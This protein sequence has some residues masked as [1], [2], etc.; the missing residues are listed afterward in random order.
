MKK[1]GFTLIE[2]LVVIAIIAILA[3][4]LLPA[5]QTAKNLARQTLC[6]GNLK[7]IG[8][9]V[10]SY[11]TDQAQNRLP[12]GATSATYG[13]TS[14][15]SWDDLVSDYIG[16]SLTESM[17]AAMYAP[18]CSGDNIFLCPSDKKESWNPSAN[19]RTYAMVRGNNAGTGNAAPDSLT[20]IFGVAGYNPAWSASLSMIPDPSGTLLI[21]EQT[22]GGSLLGYG[23]CAT[24][25]NPEAHQK[26]GILHQSS[27]SY[28]YVDIHAAAK[29][30]VDTFGPGGSYAQPRGQWTR[31]KGD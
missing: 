5:L 13:D 9:A 27:F 3:S 22:N 2:L 20:N 30:P 31:R 24:M 12:Y 21:S 25:D 26:I 23:S 14:E 18:K 16:R 1:I 28:L 19:R 17:K 4:L 10:A 7:Q 6:L 8:L 29:K 15:I 11:T